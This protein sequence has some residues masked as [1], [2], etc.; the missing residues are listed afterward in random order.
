MTDPYGD[1]YHLE[2]PITFAIIGVGGYIAKKHLEAIKSVNGRI[3]AALDPHDSVGVLDYYS[4]SAKFF[5]NKDD[6]FSYLKTNLPN[7]IV[8]CSPNNTHAEYIKLSLDLE[9]SVIC[10]K[11]LVICEKDL[12]D[13]IKLDYLH[14]NK[15]CNILQLRLIDDAIQLKKEISFGSKEQFYNVKLDY[16]TP[17]GDW[18]SKSWKNDEKQ[19]GGIL[20][21]IGIH[22]FDMLLWL[23]GEVKNY[24]IILLQDNKAQ[25]FFLFDNAKVDWFLSI[26]AADLPIPNI[27]LPH[28]ILKINNK[29]IDLSQSFTNLHC[30]LYK[31]II[32]NN[33]FYIKDVVDSINLILELKKSYGPI[34][35]SV[36]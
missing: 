27:N 6:F 25:G 35:N 29:N 20:F 28:R 7:Y 16:I 34:Q 32:N 14:P 24:D 36:F 2:Q 5:N 26:D 4:I 21:N 10:E 23:F 30:D 13:L 33:G 18:Y 31:L 9:C 11:P 22:F 3:V 15:I 19:S 12:E 17:R 8:I 1:F